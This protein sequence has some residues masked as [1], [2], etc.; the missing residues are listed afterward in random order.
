L[1][2]SCL[3]YIFFFVVVFFPKVEKSSRSC[4]RDPFEADWSSFVARVCGFA[5]QSGFMLNECVS[6]S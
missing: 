1:S 2:E 6:V 3:L 4:G 5:E